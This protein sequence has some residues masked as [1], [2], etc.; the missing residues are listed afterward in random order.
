MSTPPVNSS[1]PLQRLRLHASLY[2]GVRRVPGRAFQARYYLGGSTW[3]HHQINLGTYTESDHGSMELAEW[4]AGQACREFDRSWK[5][6]PITRQWPTPWAVVK[7]LQAA[8]IVPGHVLPKWVYRRP[9]GEYGA[10]VKLRG[11]AIDLGPYRTPEAA[12]R[13]MAAT[14]Q[15]R[16]YCGEL[17]HVATLFGEPQE[18]APAK[19]KTVPAFV[20][21]LE[22]GRIPLGR[23][24]T[25]HDARRAVWAFLSRY[26]PGSNPWSVVVKLQAKGVVPRDL[27]PP[28]VA[29]VA[30]NSCTSDVTFRYVQRNADVTRT[31]Q[32]PVRAFAAAVRQARERVS[33]LPPAGPTL[34]GLSV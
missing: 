17:G 21:L 2:E 4:A 22:W 6:D 24:A 8:G 31:Y 23:Y 27:L 28:R 12:H 32:S 15:D 29:R 11:G 14:L 13:A 20:R 16:S 5:P 1:R 18:Q 33:E 7:D 3:K 9:G 26:R 30:N 10:K 34:F 25:I 19:R